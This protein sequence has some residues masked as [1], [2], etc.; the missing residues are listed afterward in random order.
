MRIEYEL[1][2]RDFLLFN[3]MHQLLSVP[4]QVAYLGFAT[5]IFFVSS[6][7]QSLRANAIT[8]L[9]VYVAMWTVQLVFNVFYLLFGKNRSLFTKYI[10]EIQE[11]YFYE[12]TCFSRS[13]H[14]WPGVVKVVRRFGFIAV[15]LN[16][17][18]AHIIPSRAFLTVEQRTQFLSAL[19]GK[20]S[21]A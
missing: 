4:V 21:A 15:Y 19:R 5:L 6:G 12:E 17:H 2:Y 11:D 1:K 16:A 18:Y 9:L 10:V 7:D 20:V 14:Y 3:C 8:A 13:Y